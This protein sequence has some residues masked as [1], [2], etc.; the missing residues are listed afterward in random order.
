LYHNL[1]NHNS[2]P[3]SSITPFAFGDDKKAMEHNIV[4]F[5]MVEKPRIWGWIG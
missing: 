1:F 3:C 2:Y 4:S 5:E